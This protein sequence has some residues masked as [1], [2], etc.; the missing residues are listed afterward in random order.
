LNLHNH[1]WIS[2]DLINKI[3]YFAKNIEELVLSETDITDDVLKELSISCEY[4]NS[5]DIS[6]CKNLTEKGIRTFLEVKGP[7][8]IKFKSAH[9]S[10]SVTDESI[11]SI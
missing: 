8:I 6:K 3:G 9:N 11:E 5:I 2:N 1:T 4:L 7:K 10:N